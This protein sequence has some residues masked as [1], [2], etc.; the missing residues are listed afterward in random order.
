MPIVP[1]VQ[2]KGGQFTTDVRLDRVREVDLRSLNHLVRD[3]LTAEEQKLRSFSYQV[4]VRLDQG[5]EGACVGNGYAHELAGYSVKVPGITN[6]VAR[7]LYFLFQQNDSWPGGAYPGATPFYEGTSVLAGAQVLKALGFYQAY[8]WSLTVQ[9]FI[10]AI[11]YK[12]IQVMGVDWY[13]GMF[14]VDSDGYI[15]PT[16]N[17][18]G[19]HCVAVVAV[20]LVKLD[21]NKLL[22]WDNVDWVKSF[23]TILNSWGESWGKAGLAKIALIDLLKLWPGGDFLCPV[24]RQFRPLPVAA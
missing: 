2:L 8:K 17:I 16:G 10:L 14:D 12:G 3:E 15:R 6:G 1:A 20:K 5:Q 19:G 23:I 7:A 4:P 9:E 22:T 13:D 18:A 21:K 24:G 11:A